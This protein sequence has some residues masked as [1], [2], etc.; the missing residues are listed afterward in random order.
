MSMLSLVIDTVFEIHTSCNGDRFFFRDLRF[1]LQFS[2]VLSSG[3]S[4][5]ASINVYLLNS[6]TIV[7]PHHYSFYKARFRHFMYERD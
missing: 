4:A 2:H 7:K 3:E 1:D 6:L 5:E